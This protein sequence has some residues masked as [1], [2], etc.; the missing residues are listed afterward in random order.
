MPNGQ[1]LYHL[2]RRKRAHNKTKKLQPYPHPDKFPAFI[3]RVVY[4]IGVIGPLLGGVQVYKIW[5]TQDATGVSLS[6]FGFSMIFNM[7]W[8]L[9][10]V[11]HKA[12][13]IILMYALWFITNALI[14]IGIL[15]YG[16][17]I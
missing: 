7:I 15:T 9:Y 5:S 10:G 8:I 13:P 12:K 4:F 16:N 2:H 3:D 14:T 1:G 6:L 17:V 11:I